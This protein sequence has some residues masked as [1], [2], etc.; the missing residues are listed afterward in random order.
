MRKTQEQLIK[1]FSPNQTVQQLTSHLRKLDDKE[2][3][4]IGDRVYKDGEF[5]CLI[6]NK[7]EMISTIE[8]I[9]FLIKWNKV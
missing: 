7:D 9:H 2:Y 4:V 3:R 5:W 1:D 6:S 8:H